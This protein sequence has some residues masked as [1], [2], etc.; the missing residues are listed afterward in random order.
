MF[1]LCSISP[2]K[3]REGDRPPKTAAGRLKSGGWRGRARGR[4]LRRTL[5]TNRARAM[6]KAMS[7]AEVILWTRLR[8]RRADRPTFRRQHP[9]G[10]FILDFYCPSARLDVEVDGATDWDDEAFR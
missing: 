5:I 8:G 6:R 1:L 9:F 7:G 4:V 10:P 2:A 3:R